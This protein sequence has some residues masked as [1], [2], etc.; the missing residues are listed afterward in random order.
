MKT[1][2]GT[3]TLEQFNELI[4]GTGNNLTAAHDVYF[5]E[6]PPNPSERDLVILQNGETYVLGRDQDPLEEIVA[7]GTSFNAD[8]YVEGKIYFTDDVEVIFND[9]FEI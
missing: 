6:E 8:Y 3:Y 7:Y 4:E 2:S 5:Y 9:K 1:I